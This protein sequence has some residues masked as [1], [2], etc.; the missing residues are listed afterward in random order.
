MI[1]QNSPSNVFI[2]PLPGKLISTAWFYHH[3]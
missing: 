1:L 3:L 2:L